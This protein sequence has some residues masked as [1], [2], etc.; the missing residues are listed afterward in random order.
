MHRKMRVLGESG[1][2]AQNFGCQGRVMF[3]SKKRG[4]KGREA[5]KV[6]EQYVEAWGESRKNA[7]NLGAWGEW[8]FN[9]KIVVIRATKGREG[10]KVWAKYVEAWAEW[11]KMAWNFGGL[12]R[13]EKNGAEFW[14]PGASGVLNLGY[15][16]F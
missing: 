12:G 6:G 10:T 5:T 9:R 14:G 2:N 8:C 7:R 13:V 15:K 11:R 3:K 4:Y 16:G 1:E